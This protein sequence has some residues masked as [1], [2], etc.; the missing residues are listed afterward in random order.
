M[1]STTLV[2][3]LMPSK[4][5]PAAAPVVPEEDV[6]LGLVDVGDDVVVVGVAT[7]TDGAGGAVGFGV[8][9]GG[10]ARGEVAATDSE[11]I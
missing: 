8:G 5:F 3:R 1:P 7:D 9:V 6:P 11:D 10:G 2:I 4:F